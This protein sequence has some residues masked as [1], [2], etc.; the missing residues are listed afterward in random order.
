MAYLDNTPLGLDLGIADLAVI[1]ND[2]ITACTTR[3]LIGPAN[4]LGKLGIGI[5]E[6]K[7]F[8]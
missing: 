6:E 5:R 3:C 7:L 8:I 2:R 1:D 4:A